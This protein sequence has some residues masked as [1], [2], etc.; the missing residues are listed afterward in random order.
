METRTD[1][2]E[3][4]NQVETKT[5]KLEITNQVETKTVKLTITNQVR[6]KDG[7]VRDRYNICHD[8][9]FTDQTQPTEPKLSVNVFII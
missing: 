2:L 1:K 4:T 6:G 7:Q 3:I 5:V 8:F 9:I